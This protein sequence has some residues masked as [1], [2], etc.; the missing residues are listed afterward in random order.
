MMEYNIGEFSALLGITRDTLRLYEKH[1]IVQ[2][3]KDEKNRY[4]YFDDFDA[5]DLLM[6]RWYRSLQ[7]PLQ[8]VADMMQQSTLDRIREEVGDSRHNLQA[9]IRRS[10]MLLGKIDE[11]YRE[12][13]SLEATMNQCHI[14]TRPGMYR[15]KQTKK[16]RLLRNDVLKW[17]VTTWMELLPF[18]FYSFRIESGETDADE[19]DDWDYSWGLSLMEDDVRSLEVIVPEHAEYLPPAIG[20]SATIRV[21]QKEN[22]SRSS[23]S[24]MFDYLRNNG[25]SLRGDIVGRI[26]VNEKREKQ[27]WY[28]LEV[29]MAI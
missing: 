25:Y 5:R 16:N 12:L 9:Q 7:L 18:T 13:E 24:F 21:H 28:Y 27:T 2:P 4:R 22:I 8:S 15:L 11:I 14:K 1:N 29:Y 17:D 6:S 26:I 3:S 10:T 20:I 19:Q 23:L